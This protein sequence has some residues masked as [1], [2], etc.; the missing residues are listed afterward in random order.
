M[1][2]GEQDGQAKVIEG[3]K[4]IFYKNGKYQ[5]EAYT[6]LVEAKYIPAISLYTLPNP[7]KL[8]E[9]K[10]N[11]GPNFKYPITDG[12]QFD[13]KPM[14]EIIDL[15]AQQQQAAAEEM[16]NNGM[17]EDGNENGQQNLDT[18]AE[19]ESTGDDFESKRVKVE[20]IDAV[21]NVE[22]LAAKDGPCETLNSTQQDHHDLNGKEAIDGQGLSNQTPTNPRAVDQMAVNPIR[23]GHQRASPEENA[24]DGQ[25][26]SRQADSQATSHGEENKQLDS[27]HLQG[28]LGSDKLLDSERSG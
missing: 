17:N 5:V 4:I 20:T 28:E 23:T 1:P 3:S 22:T 15:I 26:S 13:Y 19:G 2:G 16:E 6:D 8:A 21:S 24:D 11:F 9:V 18:M 14:S 25:G 12:P 7:S 10:A 27:L